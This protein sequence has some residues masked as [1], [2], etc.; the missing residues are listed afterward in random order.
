MDIDLIEFPRKIQ[1]SH[2]CVLQILSNL[3]IIEADRNE[4]LRAYRDPQI[5]QKGYNKIDHYI[6]I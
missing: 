6:I 3:A 5:P 2:A 4:S 1:M